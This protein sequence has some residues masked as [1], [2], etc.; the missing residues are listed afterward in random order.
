[1]SQRN[2]PFPKG[3]PPEG[4]NVEGKLFRLVENK[5][6]QASDFVDKPE[7]DVRSGRTFPSS[8][9][10]EDI[11]LALAV[12]L[13]DSLEAAQELRKRMR[14][15]KRSRRRFVVGREIPAIRGETRRT[16]TSN[17]SHVSWWPPFDD[18]R[19]D[20]FVFEADLGELNG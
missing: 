19:E 6:P 14:G 12:S 8:W 3:C 13:G 15:K 2:V 16:P 4:E 5:P 18:G 9:T 1:V 17:S 11:C 10:S 7:L 20:G